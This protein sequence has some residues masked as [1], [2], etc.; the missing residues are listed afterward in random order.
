MDED[1]SSTNTV[2]NLKVEVAS[3]RLKGNLIWIWVAKQMMRKVRSFRSLDENNT[4]LH[5]E[6]LHLELH[7]KSFRCC[8]HSDCV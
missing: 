5:G 6:V 8:L 3:A 1:F 7:S 2:G 4:V